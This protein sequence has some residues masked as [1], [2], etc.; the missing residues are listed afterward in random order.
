MRQITVTILNRPRE[1]ENIARLLKEAGVNILA[2]HLADTE[3]GG[4]VQV[5]CDKHEVALSA[6]R[7]DYKMFTRESE[8][9]AVSAPHVPGQLARILSM[10]GNLHVSV[11][12]SYMS[13][14]PRNKPVVLLE[15]FGSENV[16]TAKESLGACPDLSIVDTLE[17]QYGTE[18]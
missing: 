16:R 6:L 7:G 18:S 15:F 14:D 13:M 9:L 4:F 3:S 11:R 10:L 1:F 2:F 8:I 12:S 17:G 5:V